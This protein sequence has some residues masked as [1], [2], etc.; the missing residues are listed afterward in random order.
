[1]YANFFWCNG[2]LSGWV[3]GGTFASLGMVLGMQK[4][5]MF[6]AGQVTRAQMIHAWN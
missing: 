4:V 6:R 3:V 5:W 2:R 1:M